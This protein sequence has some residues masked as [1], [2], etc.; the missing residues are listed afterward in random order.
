MNT[1]NLNSPCVKHT[2]RYEESPG[3]RLPSTRLA[4]ALPRLISKLAPR[5]RFCAERCQPEG[6]M[7]AHGLVRPSRPSPAWC[8]RTAILS[9]TRCAGSRS[10]STVQSAAYP[11]VTSGGRA[12]FTSRLVSDRGSISS[13]SAT[14]MKALRSLQALKC[15]PLFIIDILRISPLQ[16]PHYIPLFEKEPTGRSRMLADSS[17]EYQP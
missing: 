12:W 8:I 13:C 7:Q 17:A 9:A 15:K 14:V 2:D 16:F 5:Q 1:I 4:D 11:S 10:C 3:R 6:L